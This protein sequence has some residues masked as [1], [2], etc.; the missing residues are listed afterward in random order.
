MIFNSTISKRESDVNLSDA[1]ATSEDILLG[2]TAYGSSGKLVG[3]LVP[4]TDTSDA[5]ATSA[6]ILSGKTAYTSSGKVSGTM[7]NRGAVSQTLSAGAS[8]TIPAGYHN[9]FGTVTA[10]IATGSGVSNIINVTFINNSSQAIPVY[11]TYFPGDTTSYR[12][13]NL[14]SNKTSTQSIYAGLLI[15]ANGYVSVSVSNTSI[16]HL[17]IAPYNNSGSYVYEIKN[18]QGAS[19]TITIS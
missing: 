13:I 15:V 14:Q 3:T 5:T 17:L 16:A 1:T 10:T 12:F 19:L 9:G 11:A 4:G 2:K 6:D 7:I 8:Y 18:I